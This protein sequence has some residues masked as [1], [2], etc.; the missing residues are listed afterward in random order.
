[1]I[2]GAFG[3]SQQLQSFGSISREEASMKACPFD[4]EASAVV[5]LDEGY[6]DYLDDGHGLVTWYHQKI[7]ILKED[8]KKYADI[9]LTYYHDDEFEYIDNLEAVAINTDEHGNR[10]DVRV[11]SKSFFPKKLNKVRSEITF[12]FPDVKVGSIIEYKYRV[13][14]KHYGGLRDWYFQSAIPV[15]KSAYKLKI[16]P[17]HE[18]SYL[19]QYNPKYKIEVKNDKFDHA[20][21]FEMDNI[22]AL[23]DEPFMDAREDYIQKVIFQ[24]TKYA[25]YAGTI[26]Y[27][28]TWKEVIKELQGRS[29]F[30]RQLKV[31][32]EECK[33]VILA[34]AEAK[35][36]LEKM[37]LV[38]RYVINN[39]SW[40]GNYS[41]VASDGVKTLARKK[42]GNSGQINLLLINL[43][44]EA[45]LEVY[46][47]LVSERGHGR[48]N[49]DQPFI[50][51]FNNVYAAVFIHNNRY[52]LD[53]TDPY[54]PS[55]IIPYSILIARRSLPTIKWEDL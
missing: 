14:A 53:G 48:V 29:D 5:L 34:T 7:K 18:V 21:T 22:P 11:E 27:M 52:Y 37:N 23:T 19:V 50:N 43:L 2:S 38:H 17:G 26:N 39:F 10:I 55:H 24:T 41:L 20:V 15:I 1:M 3:F 6:S 9:R 28:S 42:T 16:V 51:Q 30:G 12:A 46:P 4:A 45:G 8:G 31:N 44:K 25:G 40:D 36:D 49:K 54:T 32:V 47:M 33:D 35:N 13:I